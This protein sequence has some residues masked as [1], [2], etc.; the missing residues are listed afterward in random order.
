MEISAH[1]P[2]LATITI[3]GRQDGQPFTRSLNYT[4]DQPLTRDDQQ[5][6]THTVTF[7]A[8]GGSPEP[9]AQTV[10]APYGRVKRPT[11]DPARDGFQFDGCS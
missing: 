5:G 11:P 1:K 4:V 3:A 8:D 10:S 7:N 2:G 6:T 9:A